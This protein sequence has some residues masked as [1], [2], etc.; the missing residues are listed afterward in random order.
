MLKPICI[1]IFLS[2]AGC[3]TSTEKSSAHK[4][5]QLGLAKTEIS[6]Q[7]GQP[8]TNYMNGF[9]VYHQNGNEV[10]VHF[11]QGKA[12]AIFYYTFEK[13]ISD[14]LLKI[15]LSQN[16]N[17]AP[18]VLEA[19]SS[20]TGRVAYRTKDGQHHAFVSNGNQL[21]VDIDSFFQKSVHRPGK[22]IPIDSLPEGVF[23][24]DHPDARIGG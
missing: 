7:L 5:V 18:W 23:A 15:I 24:P 11:S 12:D 6:K 13:R 19:S 20:K 10:Q 4:T 17:A 1:I 16:S 2:L 22:I 21:L 3:A 8:T 9:H 14:A